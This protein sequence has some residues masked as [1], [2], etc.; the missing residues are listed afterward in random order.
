[1]INIKSKV[2]EEVH[3]KPKPISKMLQL[4]LAF[5]FFVYSMDFGLYK[6]KT[7]L[8]KIVIR[9]SILAL[10]PF[11][12]LLLLIFYVPVNYVNIFWFYKYMVAAY[13][14]ILIL[15]TIPKNKSFYTFLKRLHSIDVKLGVDSDSYRMDIK[16][17]IYF[18]S[19]IAYKCIT[20]S[21]YCFYFDDCL[22]PLWI[23]V[24]YF[25]P[26][27]SMDIPLIMFFFIFY[28]SCCRLVAFT[29][30][31]K[32]GRCCPIYF[33]NIYKYLHDSMETAIYAF[34]PLVS[35]AFLNGSLKNN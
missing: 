13:L 16:L 22:E 28:A 11:L 2:T 35:N 3:L 26:Y 9:F 25:I 18:A 30:I 27:L 23:Q 32:N 29:E 20:W 14:H 7:C 6:Y 15:L 31:F 24:L 10:T 17:L 34:V 19:S 8:A 5:T 21:V 12:S 1:M 33:Q 4:F